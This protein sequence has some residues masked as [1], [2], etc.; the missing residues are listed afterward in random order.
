MVQIGP[1]Q[2]GHKHKGES[3]N[4]E[5]KT[6]DQVSKINND[7]IY[8]VP[9]TQGCDSTTE[10]PIDDMKDKTKSSIQTQ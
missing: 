4:Q 3:F 2:I 8:Y 5:D 6:D 10:G 7:L 1:S 9:I